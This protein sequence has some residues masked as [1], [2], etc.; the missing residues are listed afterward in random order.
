LL[1]CSRRYWSLAG[2]LDADRRRNAKSPP[3]PV[4]VLSAC[5]RELL[6]GVVVRTLRVRYRPSAASVFGPAFQSAASPALC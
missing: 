6:L 2:R 1:V 4:G 3:S 5:S